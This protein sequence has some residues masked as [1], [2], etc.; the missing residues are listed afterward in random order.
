MTKTWFITGANRGFGRIWAEAAL[1]RGDRVAA[2][3]RDIAALA[4]LATEHGD[5]LA[6][7]ALDV[8]DRDG[9]FRAVARA[10]AHFGG[11]DVVLSN[12]G[13]GCM[14]AVEEMTAEA[15]RANFDTN[16][17]GTLSVIQ[18]AVPLLRAQGHGHILTVSSIGGVVSFPTAGV[19][20]ATKHAVEALSE[21][22]AGEVAGFG[23]KVT[24]IEPGSFATDFRASIAFAPAMPDYDGV[25]AAVMANFK[26]EMS[27]NPQATA[28][29][30]L[31]VVDAETPPLRL[32]LGTGPLPLIRQVYARRLAA[33]EEW[34][35]VSAAAQGQ[36]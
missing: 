20:T 31:K 29:A 6:P 25:R 3:A 2:T 36:R 15:A 17:F 11:L 35:E 28:D 33:W 10:H 30:I 34:A 27:G 24:I 9:V 21:A 32:L 1:R 7:L 23:I 22:L 4:D 5:R 14:G 8:T 18:A 26:P 13:Y 12:A 19:Y 16:V